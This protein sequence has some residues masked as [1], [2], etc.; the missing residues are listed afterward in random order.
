MYEA[1]ASV[2]KGGRPPDPGLALRGTDGPC[3]QSK[4]EAT[5]GADE[6]GNLQQSAGCVMLCLAWHQVRGGCAF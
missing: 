4:A 5:F 6:Q 3:S 1:E 2:C